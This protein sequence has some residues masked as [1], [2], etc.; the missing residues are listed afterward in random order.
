ME[1]NEDET[2]RP[3]FR[4]E[5]TTV[6]YSCLDGLISYDYAFDE[7]IA[8]KDVCPSHPLASKQNGAISHTDH[9]VIAL[10]LQKSNF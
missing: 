9:I 3:Y 7:T 2:V 1:L 5:G 8:S 10:S 4:R 6:R